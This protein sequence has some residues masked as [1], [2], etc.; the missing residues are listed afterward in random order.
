M[1]EKPA[2]DLAGEFNSTILLCLEGWWLPLPS[3]LSSISLSDPDPLLWWSWLWWLLD[4]LDLWATNWRSEPW[5]LRRSNS[6]T[7][8][9]IVNLS[10]KR[11]FKPSLHALYTLQ[12][13]REETFLCTSA[14]RMRY[15]ELTYDSAADNESEKLWGCDVMTPPRTFS[16]CV[17]CK[18][19]NFSPEN[20]KL[21][22]GQK[23]ANV[24]RLLL[25]EPLSTL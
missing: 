8:L 10:E 2:I 19:S 16:P 25:E 18:K 9:L 21:V 11:N 14:A 4:P 1:P 15:D 5:L 13:I 22:K 20:L 6:F 17:T 24:H 7:T 12:T 23:W 3:S